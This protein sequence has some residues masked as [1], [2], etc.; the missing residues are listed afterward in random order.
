M[1]YIAWMQTQPKL[2]QSLNIS[3]VYDDEAPAVASPIWAFNGGQDF[4]YIAAPHWSLFFVV[5]AIAFAP[6]IHWSRRFSL[7]TLLGKPFS[8][9]LCH[10]NV[11]L[12]LS[13]NHIFKIVTDRTVR[14]PQHC[15]R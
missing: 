13:K 6:W 2:F 4:L 9:E 10:P 5:V 7:R 12:A 11:R 15:D 8:I 1:D 3:E 14:T